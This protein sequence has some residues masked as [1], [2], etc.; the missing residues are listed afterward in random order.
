MVS[1]V[2]PDAAAAWS[3]ERGPLWTVVPPAGRE[4]LDNLVTRLLDLA[5]DGR[6]F[7]DP[8]GEA[9]HRA[10]LR[11]GVRAAA[12]LARLVS[13]D[14]ELLAATAMLPWFD[15]ALLGA[16]VRLLTP[17]PPDWT[18][19]MLLA[20]TPPE[21]RSMAEAAGE[22]RG[23]YL[24]QLAA[25]PPQLRAAVVLVRY[26]AAATPEVA[27]LSMG[28]ARPFDAAELTLLARG[29]PAGLPV[30][31]P[32]PRPAAP[33]DE[34]VG[35]P[36]EAVALVLASGGHQLAVATGPDFTVDGVE[37]VYRVRWNGSPDRYPR[38]PAYPGD[39]EPLPP[40][41]PGWIVDRVTREVHPVDLSPGVLESYADTHREYPLPPGWRPS[42]RVP[43][44][45]AL[46]ELLPE[47]V[48]ADLA[49][50]VSAA[51]RRRLADNTW[52]DYLVAWSVAEQT[53]RALPHADTDLLAASLLAARGPADG[54]ALLDGDPP[55]AYAGALALAESARPRPDE[56]DGPGATRRAA[57]LADEPVAVRRLAVA[58]AHAR[59]RVDEARFGVLP[60]ARAAEL[61]ALSILDIRG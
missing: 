21:A 6:P 14:A 4:R 59:A 29:L 25:L 58:N 5:L 39:P 32:G 3:A 37:L 17:G 30:A 9:H 47:P 57:A 22:D 31:A 60:A 2:E 40:R 36:A 53:L 35:S 51:Y 34:P 43:V 23:R 49:P 52:P 8:A 18:A 13:A 20:M 7:A 1:A 10:L 54:D 48:R 16:R 26:A 56:V 33:P 11:V 38:R 46:A 41:E 42:G 27:A 24:R 15:D 44:G 61:H 19:A 28:T 50:A 55:P 45:D 12:E